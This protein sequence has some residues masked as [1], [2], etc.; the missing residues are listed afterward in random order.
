M[1]ILALTFNFP[2]DR[3]S[4]TFEQDTVNTDIIEVEY[5]T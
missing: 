4:V 2:P 3:G 1:Y 5:N